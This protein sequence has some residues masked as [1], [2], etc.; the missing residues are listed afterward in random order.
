MIRY[1]LVLSMLTMI[2]ISGCG[3]QTKTLQ[4]HYEKAYKLFFEKQDTDAAYLELD[5]IQ[6]TKPEFIAPYFNFMLAYSNDTRHNYHPAIKEYLKELHVNPQKSKQDID[7]YQWSLS[8]L[9]DTY[10]K[11]GLLYKD[12][13]ELAVNSQINYY[14]CKLYL[15][16]KIQKKKS[17]H[18]LYYYRGLCYYYVQEIDKAIDDLKNTGDYLP[19]QV[20]LG[21][22]YHLKGMRQESVRVWDN[23]RMTKDSG[24]LALLG[25]IQVECGHVPDDGLMLC[26]KAYHTCQN[27]VTADCLASVYVDTGCVDKALNL[28]N[29]IKPDSPEI[30]D[31]WGGYT[32]K[33]A[34]I[35]IAYATKFYDPQYLMIQAKAYFLKAVEYYLKIKSEYGLCQAGLCQLEAGN[36][37]KAF[38]MLSNICDSGEEEETRIKAKINMG[39]LACLDGREEEAF[40]IWD[41]IL[42]NSD[43]PL[44]KSDVG[45]SYAR[46]GVK[47]D[48]AISLCKQTEA[49]KPGVLSQQLGIAY[50]K[51]GMLDDD[52]ELLSYAIS[53]LEKNHIH[54][55]GYNLERNDPVVLLNLVRAYYYRRVFNRPSEIMLSFRDVYPGCD[56]I[57]NAFQSVKEAWQIIKWEKETKWGHEWYELKMA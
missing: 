53:Y 42:N 16:K 45:L 17:Q 14:S 9:A 13:F 25:R 7:V 3:T 19:A 49:E 57:F 54:E 18:Y 31:E 55:S 35:K 1:L 15:S 21:A 38:S 43:N 33:E 34:G 40:K 12:L 52:P 24:A 39:L 4:A 44:V 32:D 8:G 36:K 20:I 46:A 22:C 47:L 10:Y 48:K 29:K 50:L 27:K 26:E 37:K 11:A 41:E 6:K 5:Y 51:K 30:I 23:I 28:M 2:A 56:Q